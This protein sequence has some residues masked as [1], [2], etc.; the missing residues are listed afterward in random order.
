M[1]LERERL[2]LRAA[3]ALHSL[4]TQCIFNGDYK[5]GAEYGRRLVALDP[6]RESAQRQY[7]LLLA[8]DGQHNAALAQYGALRELLAAELAVEPAEETTTLAARIRSSRAAPAPNLPSEPTPFVGRHTELAAIRTRL[9]NP[10]C[11]LLTLVGPGGV[12]KTR[13]AARAAAGNRGAF[14]HGVYFVRLASVRSVEFVV[15]AIADALKLSLSD[16]VDPS[17]ALLDYLRE[18]ALL[19][20]LDGFEHLL[21]GVGL[22]S[23]I[24]DAAPYVKMLAASQQRLNL[25]AEWL[26]D[27]AGLHYPNE[28]ESAEADSYSAV[29]LFQQIALRVQAD[30]SLSEATRPQVVRVCRLLHGLPLGIELAAAWVRAHS[31]AEIAHEIEHS[32]DY[33]ATTLRDVP[34]RQRSL[35]ATFEHSWTLL[36][37]AERAAVRKLSV[38]R[39]PFTLEAAK[40]IARANAI[41]LRVLEEKSFLSQDQIGRFDIHP[42]LKQYIAEKLAVTPL[43]EEETH[44]AH[45]DFYANF[46]SE[47]AQTLKGRGQQVALAEI[48]TVIDDVRAAWKWAVVCANL[49]A[50]ALAME[51]LYYFYWARNWLR[52]GQVAF[53]QAEEAVWAAD[54]T[55]GLLLAK[56]RTRRAEFQ[57]WLGE[58]DDAK[59][60]L[61]K[62]I[63]VCRALTTQDELAHTLYILGLVE[64]WLGEYSDS[65][66]DLQESLAIYRQLGDQYGMSLT[67]NNL[68]NTICDESADYDRAQLYYAES[69]AIARQIGDQFGVAR[70]LVN[71]GAISQELGKYSQANQLY[72]ES[73]SLYREIDY[74]YGISAALNYLG[75]V[76][77]LS[78]EYADAET[79]LR[80]SLDINRETGN[81][82]EITS[83]LRRLGDMAREKGAYNEAKRRYDE[84]LQLAMEIQAL[85]LT[86]EVLTS[87]ARLF[88]GEEKSE[89][90]VELLTFVLHQTKGGQEVKD[91]AAGLLAELEAGLPP[92]VVARC[93]ARGREKT[94][95]NIS[96]EILSASLSSTNIKKDQALMV[97]VAR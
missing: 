18:K 22:L 14:L 79:L 71:Q 56:I 51:C 91:R 77:Y 16:P 87:V 32:L 88:G 70:V 8:R 82:R 96:A 42:S 52:E 26:L 74:Q 61:H 50:I 66:Q 57:G 12:G 58:Y 86:L 15:P 6:L 90:A 35:R 29:Q 75:Q 43:E 13:L 20:V 44:D 72:Q 24:L 19:L 38:I 46:L 95:D 31:C 47:R 97:N 63:V 23:E 33:L 94:L 85:P 40:L 27:I 36:S 89:R 5:R 73:L 37:V 21:D 45:C 2:R 62:S 17:R 80:E 76:A 4:S 67:L 11:R 64:Y 60:A 55:E 39:G 49:A 81:R 54:E 93:H 92:E 3:E 10:K 30:F 69:L 41:T 59:T 7:M 78:G 48:D 53:A 28:G 83:S 34:E 84:A 1:V 25:R 68:A 65:R 9:A